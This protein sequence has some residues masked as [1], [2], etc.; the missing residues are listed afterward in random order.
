M[1]KG[2]FPV[3]HSGSYPASSI[4]IAIKRPVVQGVEL[5]ILFYTSSSKIP[6]LVFSKGDSKLSKQE[7]I[8][9][10]CS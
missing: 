7:I 4:I 10:F 9:E 3:V 8:V 6:P 2:V 1:L 5:L